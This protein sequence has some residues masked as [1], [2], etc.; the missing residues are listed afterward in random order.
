MV[1]GGAG[2]L[3]FKFIAR[4][5]LNKSFI[6]EQYSSHRLLSSCGSYCRGAPCA[7]TWI[8]QQEQAWHVL[9]GG[10]GRGV[11]GWVGGRA[12]WHI[13][14]RVARNHA[15]ARTN[16]SAVKFHLWLCAYH[17]LC[18]RTLINKWVCGCACC[19][20]C[21]LPESCDR[22]RKSTVSVH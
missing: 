14:K 13:G 2:A 3:Q 18:F 8:L 17:S 5:S 21:L 10:W 20:G 1:F 7:Y 4:E 16:A 19:G 9:F 11:A 22:Q 6:K 12:V 15:V